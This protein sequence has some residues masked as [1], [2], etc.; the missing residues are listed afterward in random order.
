M[1]EELTTIMKKKSSRMFIRG[2]DSSLYSRIWGENEAF[3]RLKVFYDFEYFQFL[4][5]Y[6]NIFGKL[7][8]E[9]QA[10]AEATLYFGKEHS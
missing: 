5:D 9:S 2:M 8:S 6:I 3:V 7:S 4:R 10:S 1:N